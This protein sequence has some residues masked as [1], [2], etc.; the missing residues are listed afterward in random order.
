MQRTI[1]CHLQRAHQQ[2]VVL[3]S[4]AFLQ[5]PVWQLM[6][7]RGQILNGCWWLCF[8]FYLAFLCLQGHFQGMTM[9]PQGNYYNTVLHHSLEHSL[10]PVWALPALVWE[11]FPLV[12]PH[13]LA[14]RFDSLK[15]HK[16]G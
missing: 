2:V 1:D 9:T 12:S 11:L 4:K 7:K 15:L 5:I 6:F 14:G 8:P 10:V 3:W 13:V 16:R